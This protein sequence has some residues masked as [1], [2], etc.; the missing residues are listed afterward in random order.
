VSDVADTGELTL[1][2]GNGP[3]PIPWRAA[4]G[5][6]VNVYWRNYQ[7]RVR[8]T[9]GTV[10]EVRN[11]IMTLRRSR[12]SRREAGGDQIDLTRVVD[13]EVIVEGPAAK[14][15]RRNAWELVRLAAECINRVSTWDRDGFFTNMHELNRIFPEM[16]ERK[17]D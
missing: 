10:L 12:D 3:V 11:G 5:N 15:I 14:K 9:Q 6:Y 8:E 13:V 4:P 7:G 17:N 2:K 16:Q 1:A